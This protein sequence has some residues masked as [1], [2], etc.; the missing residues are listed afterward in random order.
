MGPAKGTASSGFTSFSSRPTTLNFP[1]RFAAAI[2]ASCSG[3][4]S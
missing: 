2:S 3:G 4:Y 1:V